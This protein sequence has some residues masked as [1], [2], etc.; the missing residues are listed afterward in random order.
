MVFVFYLKN[1]QIYEKTSAEQ[2]NKLVFESMIY[3]YVFTD[4]SFLVHCSNGNNTND[5]K[6]NYQAIYKVIDSEKYL[7]IFI[8]SNQNFII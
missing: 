7:F 4:E 6:L 2:N 8:S 5:S 3:E 1:T